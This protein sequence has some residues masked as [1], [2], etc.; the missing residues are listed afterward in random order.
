MATGTVTP[1]NL[2]K[3][4]GILYWAP[5]AT[6]EPSHTPTAGKFPTTAWGAPWS[7]LGSTDAGSQWSDSLD[8]DTIT[9]AESVYA[10]LVVGTARTATWQVALAEWSKTTIQRALNGGTVTTSGTSG[11]TLTQIDPPDVG[12]EVRCMIGWQS[13]D[14]T[15]RFV[16]RQALQTG[17]LSAGFRKGSDNAT[18][19]ITWSFEKPSAGGAPYSIYLAGTG[20]SV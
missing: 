1:G 18:L 16:G 9:V 5:L 13:E 6:A 15:V 3:G 14:D 17:D 19:G 11:T 4:P 2:L 7:P 20:R 12:A 8:T 10:Q